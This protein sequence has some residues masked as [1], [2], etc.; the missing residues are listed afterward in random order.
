VNLSLDLFFFLG[1]QL[2]GFF[3]TAGALAE[4]WSLC[5]IT[6]DRSQA[7]L[8]PLDTNKRLNTS[9]VSISSLT[10]R[11]IFCAAKFFLLPQS[12]QN[13]GNFVGQTIFCS[14]QGIVL[15]ISEQVVPQL[16]AVF[17]TRVSGI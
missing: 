5:A 16:L 14:T 10:N 9:Q 13:N 6:L 15:L 2:Y 8:H 1:C 7:I 4:I 12:I 3:G 11:N 17:P